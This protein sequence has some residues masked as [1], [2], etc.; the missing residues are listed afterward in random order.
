MKLAEAHVTIVGLGLIGGSMA[1]G[2]R[3]RCARL[4]GID[5]Q[6]E[7]LQLARERGI[8]D[9]VELDLQTGL[10]E[11][12]LA[13]LAVPVGGILSILSRLGHDLPSPKYILD[14]GSTKAEVVAAMLDLPAPAA[15]LGGHPLCGK[16]TSGLSAAEASLFRGQVF[17]LTPLSRTSL[18]MRQIAD[19][20]ISALGARPLV[21]DAKDH[22]RLLAGTSHLPYILA[23]VLVACI[24]ELAASDP[25]VWKLTASG[26]RDST[27]LAGSDVQMMMDI[28]STNRAEVGR[29]IKQTRSILGRLEGALRE[30]D[31]ATLESQLSRARR[32]RLLLE[33][34]Q[35]R[36]TEAGA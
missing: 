32:Q 35:T 25:I 12:D 15:P 9:R 27:R 3:G 4:I 1:A 18:R 36:R 16:E 34:R 11:C 13:I 10:A 14:V 26:F 21:M 23:T 2:L 31:F 22:D 6:P 30:G 5:T 7:T 29:M 20:L 28:L 24:E 17:V 33:E 19:E 8:V